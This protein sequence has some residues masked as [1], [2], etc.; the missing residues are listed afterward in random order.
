MLVE[1]KRVREW[2]D[3]SFMISTNRMQ[4]SQ[5]QSFDAPKSYNASGNPLPAL[6]ILIL[7]LMM[8]GHYQ[9]SMTST[10]VHKQWGMLLVG[11][12]LARAVTYIVLYISPPSTLLPSRPPSELVT[13]FCLISGG[14]IFQLSVCPNPRIREATTLT[15]PPRTRTSWVLSSP[16]D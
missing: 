3:M 10:M 4:T 15:L 9:D 16:T 13:S 1:S 11:F 6:V 12:A 8:S 2:L 5:D 7:G 14:L